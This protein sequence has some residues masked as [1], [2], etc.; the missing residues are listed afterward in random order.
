[1]VCK[2]DRITENF[3]LGIGSSFLFFFFKKIYY[4]YFIIWLLVGKIKGVIFLILL[5]EFDA[6]NLVA[7][8]DISAIIFE[9][10]TLYFRAIYGL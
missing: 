1:M 8:M 5:L 10:V 4:F 3:I 9:N 2:F 7:F 6:T